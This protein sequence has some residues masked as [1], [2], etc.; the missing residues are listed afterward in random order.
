MVSVFAHGVPRKA[1]FFL[2]F[3]AP[4]LAFESAV[5]GAGIFWTAPWFTPVDVVIVI[6]LPDIVDLVAYVD[7]IEMHRS[8]EA[9]NM[10]TIPLSPCHCRMHTM[11]PIAN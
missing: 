9:V 11:V 2:T 1:L 5:S 7:S 10:V 4:L 8:Q 3:F 6:G